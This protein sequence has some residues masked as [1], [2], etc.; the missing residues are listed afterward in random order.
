MK[1][2]YFRIVVIAIFVLCLFTYYHYQA[3]SIFTWKID[4]DFLDKEKIEELK[5]VLSK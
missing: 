1:N 3:N 5:V 4:F 2:H